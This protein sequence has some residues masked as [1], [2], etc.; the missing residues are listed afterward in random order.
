MGGK[1]KYT[2][3]NGCKQFVSDF[4]EKL[5]EWFRSELNVVNS[6]WKLIYYFIRPNS[7]KIE[8]GQVGSYTNDSSIIHK[9]TNKLLKCPARQVWEINN[10]IGKY[11][12][13]HFVKDFNKKLMGLFQSETNVLNCMWKVIDCFVRPVSFKIEQGQV[14]TFTN[15]KFLIETLINDLVTPTALRVWKVKQ[16]IEKYG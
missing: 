11:G 8:Y 15:D 16:Y 6:A 2:E 7:F 12:C 5:S 3:R 9:L 10:Y 14:G 1:K 13:E 4:N